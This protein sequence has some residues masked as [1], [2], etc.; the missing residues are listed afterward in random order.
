MRRVFIAVP[1]YNEERRLALA[2]FTEF[3]AQAAEIAFLFVNDG[4]SDATGQMLTDFCSRRPET[5]RVLH[6]PVNRG[7]GE[8]GRQGILTAF[9][10]AP[11]SIG[12]WDA[13][14][15]TPLDM[16]RVFQNVLDL[17]PTVDLVI[18]SRVQLLGR[19]IERSRTRHY[20]G[21]VFATA[22]SLALGLRVY[23]TQC[24]AKLFRACQEVRALFEHPFLSRWIFDVEVL[25][26]LV[27]RSRVA[28]SVSAVEAII[29]EYPL[30]EWRDIG[31]SKIR[32]R[33]VVLLLGIWLG[34]TGG[35]CAPAHCRRRL[36]RT[37]LVPFQVNRPN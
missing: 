19:A 4:S 32:M 33:D 28:G 12:F 5:F 7:K 30:V 36:E 6:L 35:T 18:G 2:K 26:R 20:I 34:S 24:G 31:G 1:C 10:T 25:A 13:D 15:S 21:R 11:D 9:E 8:A 17:N 22:A 27:M 29:Y 23:D 3:A 16:I 37:R 14:L